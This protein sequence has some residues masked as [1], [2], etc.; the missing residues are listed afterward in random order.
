MSILLTATYGGVEGA[1][2]FRAETLEA[3]A[4]TVRRLSAA[5]D[6]QN[7]LYAT[8]DAEMGSYSLSAPVVFDAAVTPG[9]AHTELTLTCKE[10]RAAFTGCVPLDASLFEKCGDY[11]TAQLPADRDGKYPL[12]R[13]FYVDGERLPLCQSGVYRYPF[14]LEGEK[15]K[16]GKDPRNHR[17]IYIPEE[18]AAMLPEED[19]YPMEIT[20]F[21]E[22]EFFTVQVTG[23]DRSDVRVGEDGE[24]YV[25]AKTVHEEQVRFAAGINLCNNIIHR[26]T[27]LANHEEFLTPGTWCYNYKTGVLCYM[28]KEGTEIEETEFEIPILEN[29]IEFC[30]MD[31]ITCRNL[32]FT[33]T[34]SKYAVENGYLSGQANNELR[35]GRLP[36][37]A[38]LTRSVRR[39]TL[40][41]CNFTQLGGNGMIMLDSSTIVRITGCRFDHIGMAAL[42]IGNP[43]T[44]W[45]DPK[46]RNVDITVEGNLFYR[47]GY[48]YPTAV[49]FY[50]GM[51]DTLSFCHNTLRETAYSAV[52]IGW[53]WSQVSYALGEKV[54]VRNAEVA[55]N[56]IVDYMQILRDGAAIY[57]LGANCR[58]ETSH[59]F[60]FMHDNYAERELFDASKR[61]YYMDGSASNWRVYHSVTS[62]TP[63]PI[64]S[65][66]HVP[67][68]YTWHNRI[69]EIYTTDPV[70]DGNHHP[71]RD[72]LLGTWYLEPTLEELFQK[73]PEARS[74]ME[75]AGCSEE[76]EDQLI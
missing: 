15:P 73:Y 29:L 53:G 22:W 40:D 38:L 55:Y 41:A 30:G 18:I 17:G 65:Q 14:N 66:F 21:V 33:G 71:E 62:G 63:L 43:T 48:E 54:N 60:N 67:S 31:G 39:F 51:V 6:A 1:L 58:R 5:A 7:R 24:R 8:L 46:N 61:G 36:H 13:D 10:G 42:S 64:F 57:V 75:K 16:R 52:S 32:D 37:A 76:L 23:I 26:E 9:L 59:Q 49:G 11:Y 25:L 69:D 28:P 70:S 45:E 47:I 27:Y 74:I 2:T 35:V 12:F 3:A 68:Q 34:T 50:I 4:E 56:K 19:V 44:L 72:T 20:M